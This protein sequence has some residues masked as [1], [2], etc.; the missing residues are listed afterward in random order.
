MQLSIGT[1]V[2]CSAESGPWATDRI[3]WGRLCLPKQPGVTPAPA[4]HCSLCAAP[5]LQP[6][7]LR[8]GRLGPHRPP[9]R[10][11]GAGAAHAL[12]LGELG[13]LGLRA[14][15]PPGTPL[16][17]GPVSAMEGGQRGRALG[18]RCGAGSCT[19]HDQAQPLPRA[20]EAGLLCAVCSSLTQTNSKISSLKQ[21]L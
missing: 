17:L 5:V 18:G 2:Q 15:R 16:G 6:P 9:S 1:K 7:V 12:E 8:L 19:T 4:Y 21:P 11:S 14:A 3:N 13:K 20:T 10:H